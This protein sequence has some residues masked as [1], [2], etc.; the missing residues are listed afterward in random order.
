MKGGFISHVPLQT[1]VELFIEGPMLSDNY[2]GNG[3]FRPQ[4]LR[5]GVGQEF[6]VYPN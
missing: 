4:F 5:S 1:A 2:R 3:S 6:A